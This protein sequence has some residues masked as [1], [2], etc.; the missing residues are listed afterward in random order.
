MSYAKHTTTTSSAKFVVTIG[1]SL[2]VELLISRCIW[3]MKLAFGMFNSS[4][5][6]VTR[7][8][9]LISKRKHAV[10]TLNHDSGDIVQCDIRYYKERKPGSLKFFGN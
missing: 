6:Q 8:S 10:R 3:S 5:N 4:S 1:G 2:F 7:I 9:A